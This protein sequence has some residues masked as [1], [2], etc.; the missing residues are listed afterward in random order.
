MQHEA[1]HALHSNVM[2]IT[3]SGLDAVQMT[4]TETWCLGTHQ[5]SPQ[6]RQSYWPHTNSKSY[7]RR[8]NRRI[9]ETDFWM[10]S[11][12]A[13]PTQAQGLS[14]GTARHHKVIQQSVDAVFPDK[15]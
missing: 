9:A 12:T 1:I 14:T 3:G 2:R 10:F 11:D 4:L 8:R 7:V 5:Q 13:T 6:K 15:P